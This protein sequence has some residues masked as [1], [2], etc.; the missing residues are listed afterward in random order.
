MALNE[1]YSYH[2]VA[3]AANYVE[4]PC[5]ARALLHKL[6]IVKST[7]TFNVTLYNRAFTAAAVTIVRIIANGT[8]TRIVFKDPH[9][10]FVGDQVT[11]A[12]TTVSGYH[13]VHVVAEVHSPY[14]VTTDQTYSADATGGTGTLSIQ[15]NNM[16][17]FEILPNLTSTGTLAK[18][19]FAAY[20]ISP[21]IVNTDPEGTMG[22][23]KKIYAKFSTAGT[24]WVTL[25]VEAE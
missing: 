16:P 20:G 15:A 10:Y 23:I 17:L 7:G 12:G 3:D 11:V 18:A 24:Y 19:D 2:V 1:V 8:K 9:K 13:A 4:I 21:I 22:K 25:G 5:P 14:E 6:R